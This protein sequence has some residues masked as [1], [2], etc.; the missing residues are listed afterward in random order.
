MKKL[1]YLLLGLCFFFPAGALATNPVSESDLTLVKVIQP[2]PGSV[3]QTG[4]TYKIIWNTY[5]TN[6]SKSVYI[7]LH[8]ANCSNNPCVALAPFTIAQEA[9]NTGS[10]EWTIPKELNSFYTG[11]QYLKIS[12]NYGETFTSD[13]FTVSGSQTPEEPVPT[14]EIKVMNPL[15]GE[16]W[17]TGQTY[18]IAWTTP[19]TFI[20]DPNLTFRIELHT[21]PPACLKTLPPCAIR[22]S[23][24]F[25]I[26]DSAPNSG[27]FEWQIPKDLSEIYM[28][29]RKLNIFANGASSWFG[30]SSLFKIS[31]WNASVIPGGSLVKVS[32]SPTVYYITKQGRKLA[33]PSMK[34]L[35]AYDPTGKNFIARDSKD[36]EVTESVVFIQASGQKAVFKLEESKRRWISFEIWQRLSLTAEDIEILPGAVFD[37]YSQGTDLD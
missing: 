11:L 16:T 28:G 22:Q 14:G 7:T 33:L 36:I 23:A 17:Y 4:Q 26:S 12:P 1:A 9:P 35:L 13:I 25:L 19:P 15:G 31:R 21:E 2:A 34:A 24:P 32:A 3:W 29:E 37:S 30:K 10:F 20:Y 5:V 6:N 27:L 8:N 18:K